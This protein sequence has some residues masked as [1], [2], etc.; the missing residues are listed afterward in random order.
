MVGNIAADQVDS[1]WV[2]TLVTHELTH[3]VFADAVANP[4]HFPPRWLNEGLAVYLSEGYGV[5]A[6]AQVQEAAQTGDL[7]PLAGIAG[8]FPT[9]YE[10]FSLAY[11][12]SVAAVD[13]FIRTY[14]KDK[15]VQLITSYRG[16]VTDDEAFIAATGS[17]VAAFDAAWVTAQ[18]ADQ[19]Q[20]FGPVP[21]PA[22]PLPSDWS[23]P[24]PAGA[25]AASARPAP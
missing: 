9:S 3:I 12:E 23:T 17:D 24:D 11:A 16:G 5:S 18:G 10:R 7:M 15:L 8:L 25:P 6:R 13:F 14:G 4:Y 22:G 1:D 2:D 21:P 20:P 19:P